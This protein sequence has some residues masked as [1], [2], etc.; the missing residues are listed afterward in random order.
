MACGLGAVVLLFLIVKH[1]AGT[2]IEPAA[3]T[4]AAEHA[5]RLKA[6]GAEAAALAAR[7]EQ[8]R[9][10]NST[11]R[12]QQASADAARAQLAELEQAVQQAAA[13]NAALGAQLKSIDAR[14]ATDPIEDRSQ[15]EEEYLLGLRVEG[16]RI[17][18]LLDRS[19]SM[20][21]VQLIDVIS[22]KVRSDAAKQ[23]GP[24]WQ[25]T[26][27]TTRW[28]LQRAPAGSEVAVVAFN[29]QAHVLGGGWG[30][31]RD[32][33]VLT[34]LAQEL[35]QLV[36]T[37]PTNLEAGLRALSELKPA[38]TNVYVVTDGL[39]TQALSSPGFGS[40]CARGQQKVSGECR[41]ALFYA[42]L[43]SAPPPGVK[44]HVI[45][46]PLEGDPQAAPAY[47]NWTAQAGGLLITPAPGWP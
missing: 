17:A 43:Q 1:H 40:G 47:W 6:L 23:Q 20:T 32:Q 33:A 7:I 46:L 45:L 3:D 9:R 18:I 14:Q 30:A 25:R 42:S 8:E 34:T 41:E 37:G 21:D 19:A 13:R 29:D 35:A 44:V 10:R 22:L 12:A 11:Q 31:G 24:K 26:L 38:A 16:P 4:R 28:L 27:R 2:A 5:A 39:P 36:P 15:G